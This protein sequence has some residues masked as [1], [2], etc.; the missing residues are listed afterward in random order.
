MGLSSAKWMGK[1]VPLSNGLRV[2]TTPWKVL[3][4]FILRS[5]FQEM[6]VC[7]GFEYSWEPKGAPP[8]PRLPLK[9]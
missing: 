1:G 4:E 3:E 2:Y 5:L 9:K 7:S 8:M 6:K